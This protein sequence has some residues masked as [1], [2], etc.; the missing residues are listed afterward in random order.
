[1]NGVAERQNRTL[2]YMVRSMISHS[3]LPESFW[4]DALKTAIYI[5]NRV[6]TKAVAE[7]PYNL[8]TKKIISIK[9]LHVWGCL[10]EARPYRPNDK[11]L[12]SRTFSC[13]FI[14]YPERTREFKF[15]DPAT[16][17]FFETNN[18]RFFK[19]VDFGREDK[20]KSI[21]FEEDSHDPNYDSAES[22][23]QIMIPIVVQGPPVQDNT[24]ISHEESIEQ[25]QQPHESQEVPLRRSTR[26]LK[27][28]VPDDYV[29]FLQE[30]EN[31]IGI[32]EDDPVNIQQAMQKPTLKSGL[33]P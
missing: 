18:A 28:A 23:D 21:I 29:I 20:G 3:S 31:G 13:Y 4:G 11:K 5:L 15:Y 6:P 2:K 26:E 7:T 30:H 27:S 14:G 32:G 17:S 9:Y 22:N 8:W 1:M 12:D 19:D 24:E 33:M 25:T 10:A 16:R